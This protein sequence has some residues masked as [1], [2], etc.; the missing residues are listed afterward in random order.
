MTSVYSKGSNRLI[1]LILLEES[2][3]PEDFAPFIAI[4]SSKLIIVLIL[5]FPFSFLYKIS[6]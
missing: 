6:I 5:F 1:V 4:N 3:F 2:L